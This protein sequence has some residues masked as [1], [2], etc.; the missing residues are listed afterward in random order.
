[1]VANFQAGGAAINQL[2]KANGVRLGV[3]ALDL[4]HPTADFTVAPAMSE[5]EVCEAFATGLRCAMEGGGDLL[6]LGEMGIAN[7]TSA[8]ALCLA[9]FGGTARG[10]TGPG[11][12]VQGSALDRKVEV[13][14]AGVARHKA[15]KEDPLELLRRLGGR[16][17]AAI[18]GAVAG[19]R[20]SRRPVVLDGFICTAAAAALE[21]ARPGALDHC[22]LAHAS[23]EPGHRLLFEH[24]KLEPLLSL[25]L[26]L[27]E[28]S[29]A[30][31][32]VSIL[33]SA[34]A[35]HAGMAT[36]ADA[37]VSEGG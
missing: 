8:A 9:L 18:A 20:L 26:R 27:G 24:L 37:G 23:A 2:C 19:A 21:A 28:G 29:G 14:A 4:D 33:R 16:E 11:T 34:A 6:C 30:A 15:A 5:A 31:T 36:F 3:T 22:V 7:T 12:G 17:L 35:C 32:A 25:G 10:W 1:M 13:V